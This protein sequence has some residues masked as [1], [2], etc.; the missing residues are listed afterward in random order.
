[1]ATKK[2]KK[3]TKKHA[4]KKASKK[5]RHKKAS[6]KAHHKKKAKKKVAKKKA[7]K[8]KD[9]AQHKKE[10][11][12]LHTAL[13]GRPVRKKASKATKLHELLN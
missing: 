6:K 9:T 7:H 1:M 5:A 8:H 10:R 2:K 4:K 12:A 11:A 3:S 13:F